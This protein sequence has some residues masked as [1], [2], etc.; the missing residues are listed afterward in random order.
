MPPPEP[1]TLRVTEPLPEPDVDPGPVTEIVTGPPPVTVRL[2]VAA[3]SHEIASDRRIVDAGGCVVAGGWVTG[4]CV[5]AGAVTGGCVV[6]GAWVVVTVGW[7]VVVD[8]DVLEVDVEEVVVVGRVVV[9]GFA[10]TEVVVV[11]TALPVPSPDHGA[12]ETRTMAATTARSPAATAGRA[13]WYL[14]ESV[15]VRVRRTGLP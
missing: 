15:R 2:S 1:D 10:A 4:G 5:V 12:T 14:S 8:V 13:R 6:A 9:V 3:P 7:V 11:P